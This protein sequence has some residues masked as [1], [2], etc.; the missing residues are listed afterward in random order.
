[1]ALARVHAE[2]LA[3]GRDFES[4]GGATMRLQFQFY[5]R[6]FVIAHKLRFLFPFLSPNAFTLELLPA[7]RLSSKPD[8]EELPLLH[9][10]VW[11][12]ARPSEY[13]LPFVAPTPPAHDRRCL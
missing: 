7:R 9:H 4:L 12:R 11:A 6:A 1:M 10:R 13:S 3:V 5:F 8:A 2:N